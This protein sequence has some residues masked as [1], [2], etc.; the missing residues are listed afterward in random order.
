[1]GYKTGSN[2]DHNV[3]D[4]CRTSNHLGRRQM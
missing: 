1:M 3:I 4:V 2:S